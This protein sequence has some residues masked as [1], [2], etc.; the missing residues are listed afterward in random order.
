MLKLTNINYQN[1][2]RQTDPLLSSVKSEYFFQQHWELEYF[3]RRDPKT[4]HE[5]LLLKSVG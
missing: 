1:P 4:I 2:V 3:F 5:F